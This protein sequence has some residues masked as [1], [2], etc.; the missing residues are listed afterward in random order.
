M[1]PD[2]VPPE[3][4]D[5]LL[6]QGSRFIDVRAEIEYARGSIPGAVNLPIL[7]TSERERVG[8]CYKHNGQDAA[9]ALGHRLV[10]GDTRAARVA[11]WCAFAAEHPGSHLFCWRGGLRSRLAAQWMAGEGMPTPLIAG[12]YKALR[13]RLLREFEPPAPREPLFIIGGRTGSAKTELLADLPGAIDLEGLARHRGSSFGRL[14]L[15]PPAQIDFENALALQLLRQRHAW[16]GR[17]LFLE[18]ESR[19][20]GAVT[21]PLELYRAMKQAPLLVLD[22][23]LEQRIEHVLQI[24][25]HD[26]LR[27]FVALHADDGFA[28]FSARLLASLERIA[29][30]LGQQRCHEAAGMMR[31][32][33][34]Q[35]QRDGEVDGHRA[36]IGLLLR[37]YYDPMY[38]H[39]L[40]NAA[41]RIVFRGDRDALRSWC[42]STVARAPVQ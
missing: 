24:Y 3:H 18:D 27:S 16:P 33:L 17:A 30:R 1:T 41:A 42:L 7:T 26:D 37:E 21:I 15:E 38:D 35:Q 39:Q 12:G 28:R 22:V 40:R 32:A 2:I 11:L 29:R 23:S 34:A 20:I 25:I 10:G 31:A 9:I 5:D 4:F 36:W 6:L 8:T 13:Q 19:Q 14:A